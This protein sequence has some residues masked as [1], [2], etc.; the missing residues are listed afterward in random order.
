MEHAAIYTFGYARYWPGDLAPVAKRLGA[1]IIDIRLNPR[2]RK[3]GWTDLE[4]RQ[5]FGILGYQCLR[6]WGN[7]EHDQ[8]GMAILDIEYG[9]EKLQEIVSGPDARPV[10]LLCGCTDVNKCHRGYIADWLERTH[11]VK[12]EELDVPVSAAPPREEK[13]KPPISQLAFL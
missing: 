10:I 7:K 3:P 2:S 6:A 5:K 9:W 12:C 11:G 4:L 1:V 8:G 13:P